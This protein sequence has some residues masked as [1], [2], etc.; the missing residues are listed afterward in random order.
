[1]A[2]KFKNVKIHT[3][4]KLLAVYNASLGCWNVMKI[5]A[6]NTIRRG[7][8]NLCGF[9]RNF[10]DAVHQINEYSDKKIPVS[11]WDG[12]RMEHPGGLGSWQSMGDYF[13]KLLLT[14][15]EI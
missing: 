7:F 11:G 15:S 1:M 4:K 3:R 12:S 14:K 13:S 2:K 9:S 8:P 5:N 6:D 10:V